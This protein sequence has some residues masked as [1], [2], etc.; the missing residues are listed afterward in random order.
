M[1]N[2]HVDIKP[3]EN[4]ANEIIILAVID[5]YNQTKHKESALKF[6]RS[7]WCRFLCPLDMELILKQICPD[8][9]KTKRSDG[10][11]SARA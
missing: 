9:K 11:V 3:W 2:Y 5:V 7:E 8:N 1:S 10:D 6:L 4:L